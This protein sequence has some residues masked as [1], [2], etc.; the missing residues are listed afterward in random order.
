MGEPLD[1]DLI[2]GKEAV[3]LIDDR[4]KVIQKLSDPVTGLGR[5]VIPHP[6][7]PDIIISEPCSANFLHQI[8]DGLPLPQRVD[9]RRDGPDVLSERAHRDQ[10][11]R[12]AVELASDHA[13]ELAPT[14]HLHAPE[15]LRGHAEA[16]ISEHRRQI[17]GPIRI[18]DIAMPGYFFADL[19]DRAMEITDIRDGLA[20]DLAVRLND[21]AQHSMGARVLRTHADGHIF[22]VKA[23]AFRSQG[24]VHD[25]LSGATFLPAEPFRC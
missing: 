19:F 16:L 24:F 4:F 22:G 5:D 20:H 23:F 17:I 2:V 7:D 6:T 11:A 13:A 25:S 21:E 9:K 1:K 12:D 10:M 15:P 8:I 14:G 3:K 18:R